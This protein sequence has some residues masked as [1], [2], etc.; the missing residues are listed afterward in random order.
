LH[1]ISKETLSDFGL[2]WKECKSLAF[3]AV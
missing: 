3:L 1:K 2:N